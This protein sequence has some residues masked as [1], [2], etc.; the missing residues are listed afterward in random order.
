MQS[1]NVKREKDRL[2]RLDGNDEGSVTFQRGKKTC[3]AP[4]GKWCLNGFLFNGN[5]RVPCF[6]G[7]FWSVAIPPTVDVDRFPPV[8]WSL[9]I[10]LRDPSMTPFGKIFS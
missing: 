7:L 8:L 6:G 4:I 5:Y 9:F 1:A 3:H 2:V 10:V